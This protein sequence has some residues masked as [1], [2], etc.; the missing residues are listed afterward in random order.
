MSEPISLPQSLAISNLHIT[1]HKVAVL[2]GIDQYHNVASRQDDS[3]S[4][5]SDQP[6]CAT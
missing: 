5:F 2:V 3:K 1:D 6:R 4:A